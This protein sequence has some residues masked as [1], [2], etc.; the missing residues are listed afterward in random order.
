MRYKKNQI[1]DIF[2]NYKSN[3]NFVGKAKLIDFIEEGLSFYDDNEEKKDVPTMYSSEKW[4]VEFV[5]SNH[6]PKG[7]RRQFD[8]RKVLTKSKNPESIT[9]FTK[10][11]SKFDN[12][13]E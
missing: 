12:E 1:K 7:F 10:Y 3:S 4:L 13:E 8:I 11:K 6:Y 2:I 9:R 5:E